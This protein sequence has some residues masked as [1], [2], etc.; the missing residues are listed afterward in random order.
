[1]DNISFAEQTLTTS[2]SYQPTTSG[3]AYSLPF[4]T[5][6]AVLVKAAQEYFNSASG[7]ADETIKLAKYI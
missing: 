2:I 7:P 5:S 3:F 6:V 4:P 1:M